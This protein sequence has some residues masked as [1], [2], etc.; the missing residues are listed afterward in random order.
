[1][2]LG[3]DKVAMLSTE[4][5]G[6]GKLL[7]RF[8]KE[9]VNWLGEFTDVIIGISANGTGTGVTE[10]GLHSYMNTQLYSIYCLREVGHTFGSWLIIFH[11]VEMS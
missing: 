9:S 6:E 11:C 7:V 1:M 8:I 2:S 5:G 4:F 3:A 10:K